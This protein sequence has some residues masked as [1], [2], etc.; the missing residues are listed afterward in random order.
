MKFSAAQAL[1]TSKFLVRHLILIVLIGLVTFAATDCRAEPTQPTLDREAANRL[2]TLKV[3]PLLRVKCFGCH[4][5]DPKDLRGDYNLLTREG[6]LKGGESGD[7]SLVPGKPNES[8]LYQAVLWD[9]LEMPPKENDRVS[10]ADVGAGAHR[11]QQRTRAS[12][13][14]LRSGPE[15][16]CGVRSAVPDGPAACRR[17][18]EVRADLL[19]RMGQPRLS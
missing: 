13:E 2:F 6:M 12:A 19:R 17:G 7:T 5:N 18:R 16:D 10:H 1:R 9:G 15:R 4:G 3:L 14:S 11:S 8:S